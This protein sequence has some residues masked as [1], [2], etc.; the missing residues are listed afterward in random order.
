MRFVKKLFKAVIQLAIIGIM[1]L[2][3]FELCYRNG[4]IDFYKRE[5]E[6]LNDV[7][8]NDLDTVDYLV[9]GDSFS[10]AQPNYIDLLRDTSTKR[11]M[12]TSIPGIGIAQVNTFAN[13]RIKKY[14]PK[15]IIYQVYVGNDLT[16]IS[17]LTNW[18]ELSIARNTYWAISE[19]LRSLSY[20]NYRLGA[21]TSKKRKAKSRNI[22][23]SFDS[24]L[25]DDRSKLYATSDPYYLEKTILISQAFE[26]RYQKWV[27][28]VK[29]FLQQVP[30]DI[31]V[32]I[33]FIPHC[34]QLSM[35]YME[36]MEEIG[37][38]FRNKDQFQ[39]ET[40]PFFERATVDFALYSHVRFLNLLPYLKS[41]NYND[42]VLY[43]END[44]H[45]SLQGQK[46]LAEYLKETLSIN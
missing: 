35:T 39:K 7:S 8:S 9:F 38:K 22:E 14:K 42:E 43:Y 16:D 10:A 33:V 29:Q 25:Y 17:Q 1:V 40:Y 30:D 28:G 34:A 27:K 15:H 6:A 11:F 37:I 41:K 21:L 36:R 26:E 24:K 4:I 3:L 18:S 20:I 2:L 12:N 19:K 44:P 32:S 23:R 13:H 46:V 45:F 31:Q 5:L